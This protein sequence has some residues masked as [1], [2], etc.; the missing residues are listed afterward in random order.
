MEVA[1]LRMR[2]KNNISINVKF[3][4]D[5]LVQNKIRHLLL[6]LDFCSIYRIIVLFGG[7]VK[8]ACLFPSCT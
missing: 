5:G 3:V 6:R 8:K 4:D 7:I 2:E 1:P